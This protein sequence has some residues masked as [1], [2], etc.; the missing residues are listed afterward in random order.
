MTGIEVV[1]YSSHETLFQGLA[2]RLEKTPRGAVP[3][4]MVVPSVHFR[5]WLQIGIARRFGIC[6]GFEFFMPGDFVEEVFRAA[7]IDRAAEWSKRR[8]VWSIW[9]LA[10]LNPALLPPWAEGISLRDR[11]AMARTLADRFDQYAHFRPEMLEAWARG[12]EFQKKNP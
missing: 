6:M 8:L 3:V 2:S 9:E 7:G 1:P 12:G 11:F 10:A 4:R 5:D